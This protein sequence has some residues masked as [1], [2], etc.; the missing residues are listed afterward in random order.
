MN[1]KLPVMLTGK[2][3]AGFATNREIVHQCV[4]LR[5]A[6][7]AALAEHDLDEQ[8]EPRPL[9]VGGQLVS[10]CRGIGDD[11]YP[12]RRLNAE[13]ASVDHW[14]L[15]SITPAE[16]ARIR[17][18]LGVEP[19]PASAPERVKL[20]VNGGSSV[21]GQGVLA[22]WVDEFVAALD[23]ESRKALWQALLYKTEPPKRTCATCDSRPVCGW[24]IS[25]R[26]LACDH[27][28]EP[29]T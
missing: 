26:T 22:L 23:P 27:W 20:T 4:E 21:F 3:I 17:K 15:L 13:G 25:G 5:S 12:I 1:D 29:R 9:T 2:T 10:I 16:L 6:C 11:H 19:E 18:A 7:R 24:S 28:K 14:E 8:G